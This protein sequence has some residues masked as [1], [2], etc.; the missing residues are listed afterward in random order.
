MQLTVATPRHPLKHLGTIVSCVEATIRLP[1]VVNH[2]KGHTKS[3]AQVSP[4]KFLYIWLI[5]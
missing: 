5:E 4:D 1:L 2:F 3:K